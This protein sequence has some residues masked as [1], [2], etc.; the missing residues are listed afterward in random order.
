MALCAGQVAADE[1]VF[2]DT[3]PDPE[4]IFDCR[5]KAFNEAGASA[6]AMA[7]RMARN[8]PKT[9]LSRTPGRRPV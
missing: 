7:G 1:W 2:E 9:T 8:C 4:L 6:P 3:V 5:V